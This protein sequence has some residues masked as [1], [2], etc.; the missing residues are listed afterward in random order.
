MLPI[1]NDNY[2]DNDDHNNNNNNQII[3]S[4]VMRNP[5]NCLWLIKRKNAYIE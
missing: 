4:L 1:P 2:N 3:I 5:N